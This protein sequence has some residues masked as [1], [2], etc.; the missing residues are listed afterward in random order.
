M[1]NFFFLKNSE[2]K[3]QTGFKKKKTH[4]IETKDKKSQQPQNSKHNSTINETPGTLHHDCHR[5]WRDD[6]YDKMRNIQ[7]QERCRVTS[8]GE[9]T[10]NGNKTRE[11]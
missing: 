2:M 5:P 10:D 3:V 9:V 11:I 6:R 4:K 8:M 7:K 1:A